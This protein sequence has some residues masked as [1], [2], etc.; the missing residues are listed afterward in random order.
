MIANLSILSWVSQSYKSTEREREHVVDNDNDD[1]SQLN[2]PRNNNK[3]NKIG[4]SKS[5]KVCM[6]IYRTVERLFE[7]EK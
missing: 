2:E 1:T 7:F 4:K 6:I 3:N 5:V